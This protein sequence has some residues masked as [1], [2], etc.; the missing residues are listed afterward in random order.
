MKINFKGILVLTVIT[1]VVALLMAVTNS[2]TYPIIQRNEEKAVN[3]SLLVVMPDGKSFKKLEISNYAL[4]STIKEVY[5][6]E[7]CGYVI[8]C[9]TSG[10]S[11][12]MTILCGI[13][14]DGKITG[15][16]CIGS[17]ETLGYEKNYGKQL[18]G[19]TVDT[20]NSVDTVSGATL[21]TQGYKNAIKDS[22]AAVNILK[23]VN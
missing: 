15:A 16:V 7:S 14:T 2:L 21:T 22:F 8:K 1:T 4:P 18:I 20:I 11:E 17:S 3:D 19:V 6:E 9:V 10:Y 13:D 5:K 12:G 23:G